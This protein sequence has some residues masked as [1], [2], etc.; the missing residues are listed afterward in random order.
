MT[1]R[2]F[3]RRQEKQRQHEDYWAKCWEVPMCRYLGAQKVRASRPR[4][5]APDVD[6]HVWRADSRETKT[7]GEVTGAYYSPGEA[8]WL[9]DSESAD[10]SRVCVQSDERIGVAAIERVS[11]KLSKYSDLVENQGKGNLLVVLNSPLTK[12]STREKAERGVLKFLTSKTPDA[13]PFRSFWF[14]YRL[15]ETTLNEMEDPLFVFTDNAGRANFFKC[16]AG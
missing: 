2:K 10:G 1:V 14:A 9:W 13:R 7:W 6:F 11:R 15:P 5:N 16:I 4:H 8:Q 3:G 12:R